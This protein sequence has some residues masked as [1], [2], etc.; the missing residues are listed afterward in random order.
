MSTDTSTG[1]TSAATS[2]ATQ[3]AILEAESEMAA[4]QAET[5]IR[6]AERASKREHDRLQGEAL[7]DKARDLAI[8]GVVTGGLMIASS[9]VQFAAANA[10][11]DA[12]TTGEG[13]AAELAAKRY[14]ATSTFLQGSAKTS[15][16]MFAAIVTSDEA[17]AAAQGQA[18]QEAQARAEDANASR[19]RALS[20][21]DAKLAIAQELLRSDA[22]TMH[23][24][25]RPA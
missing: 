3:I 9:A 20:Q 19:S 14:A 16:P 18:A 13:P 15:E 17:C 23:M 11:Y 24:L 4:Y 8:G 7:R 22:D 2:I 21:L 5:V 25:I 6:E 1:A 10:Q 12:A